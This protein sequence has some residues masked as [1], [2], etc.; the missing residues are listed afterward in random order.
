M[1]N[2]LF[3]FYSIYIKIYLGH[4]RYY[5]QQ[6]YFEM[7]KEVL[8]VMDSIKDNWDLIKETLK[9]EYDL[10][11]ISYK[12]WIAPLNFYQVKDDIVTILI[13]SDQ[14][15]ALTYISI[16]YKSFFSG[17]HFGDDEPYL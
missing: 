6:G 10:S 5:P 15:H 9:K 2:L 12:T 8:L 3:E 4:F 16:K 17:N 1:D 13:P 14:S 11:D 7:K